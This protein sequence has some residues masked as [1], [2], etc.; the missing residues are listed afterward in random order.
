MLIPSL[1][2]H[3]DHIV[4]TDQNG[5]SLL[6]R[7]KWFAFYRDLYLRSSGK[8]DR[9]RVASLLE[10][11]AP[12]ASEDAIGRELARHLRRSKACQLV[13]AP[14][15]S[16]NP[17]MS[18]ECNPLWSVA[19]S[20]AC[21]ALSLS[22]GAPTPWLAFCSAGTEADTFRWAFLHIKALLAFVEGSLAAAVDDA[23]FAA[24]SA[25]CDDLRAVSQLL[26]LRAAWRLEPNDETLDLIEDLEDAVCTMPSGAPSGLLRT[27]V[28]ARFV[29]FK[30]L[31]T[32]SNE[33]P[34]AIRSLSQRLGNQSLG[35]DLLTDA[36]NANYLAVARR[37]SGDLTGALTTIAKSLV[38]AVATGD[39]H[40]IQ[41]VLFNCGHTMLEAAATS[42]MVS[43][44]D[45]IAALEVVSTI[46]ERHTIGGDSAQNELLIASHRIAQCKFA[47]AEEMLSRARR[48]IARNRS[49]YDQ[50]CLAEAELRLALARD[51]SLDR[52]ASFRQRLDAT[53]ELY[54]QA[55]RED[56]A[57]AV[58]QTFSRRSE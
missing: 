22:E 49:V 27:I 29:A 34:A 56:L 36:L 20:A 42:T 12:N 14:L 55:N 33:W 15:L 41:M 11:S 13:P 2:L 23:M 28:L 51:P 21:R 52:S 8:L 25:H 24:R 3:P 10:W 4:F 39:L 47:D 6:I 18:W 35:G 1:V 53:A 9:S 19:M 16:R 37:R 32:T 17:T 43:T 40:T 45:A 44:D 38:A 31:H 58:R 50:A 5:A 7:G 57:A 46:T 48:L 54:G 30:T 26:A